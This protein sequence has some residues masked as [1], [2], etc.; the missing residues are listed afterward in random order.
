MNLGPCVKLLAFPPEVFRLAHC[1]RWAVSA[2]LPSN[3]VRAA[4]LQCG[5]TCPSFN[6]Q[7]CGLCEAKAY[8]KVINFIVGGLNFRATSFVCTL[9]LILSVCSRY[10][11]L[12]LKYFTLA[13]DTFAYSR[14]SFFIFQTL[15]N[16][17][18][19]TNPL[20]FASA[21]MALNCF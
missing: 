5:Q 17:N 3:L 8:K 10:S 15:Q 13:T 20:I 2:V 21:V 9:A 1:H 6:L 11:I 18:K 14:N 12:V 7:E 4:Q 19:N 16:V